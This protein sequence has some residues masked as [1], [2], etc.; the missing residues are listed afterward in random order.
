LD[1]HGPEL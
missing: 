1:K